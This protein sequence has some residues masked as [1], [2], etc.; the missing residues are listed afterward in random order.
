MGYKWECPNPTN[1]ATHGIS[2]TTFAGSLE[3]SNLRFKY[4]ET[5]FQYTDAV[6]TG[7]LTFRNTAALNCSKF[8]NSGGGTCHLRNCLFEGVSTV[9]DCV[10]ATNI[11]L[12]AN[13]GGVSKLRTT[14][15]IFAAVTNLVS[16]TDIPVTTNFTAVPPSSAGIFQTV[17]GGSQLPKL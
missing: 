8:L 14:N 1:R 6:Q 17:G 7:S 9:S 3:L 10:E 5:A 2:W 12:N 4:F 13:D 11:L 15:C 16:Q